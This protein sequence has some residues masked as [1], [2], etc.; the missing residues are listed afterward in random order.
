MRYLVTNQNRLFES[1]EYK[2]IDIKTALEL[3]NKENILGVD[4]ETSGLDA[5]SK[6][7]LLLQIG[8]SEFQVAVDC[9][10]VNIL[11]FKSLLE[12]KNKLFLF[13]NAKFDLQFLYKYGIIVYNIYDSFL[14]ER[15]LWIGYPAGIHLLSLQSLCESYLDIYLDK[16]VR[17]E[18]FKGLTERVVVYG[19]RDV[20]FLLPLREKQ[21]EQIK[22]KELERAVELENEFVRALAYIEWCGIKLDV[23][24]WKAKMVT[25]KIKLEETTNALNKW[26]SD[27]FPNSE[28]CEINYQGDLF[29]GFD[30]TPK[31]KLNWQSSKQLIPF[32]EMLGYKLETKDKKTGEIKKSIEVKILE[33]QGGISSILPIYLEYS[34]AAKIVSTYGQNIINQINSTTGR[35]HT[36]Y[37]SLGADTG[38]LSSGGK[39]KETGKENMN[40]QN[41]PADAITRGCFVAEPGNK[42]ICAD[43]SAQESN[44]IACIADDKAMI[45]AINSG[46]DL[47]NLTAYMS[48]MEIPRDTK[49]ADIKSKFKKLRDKSKKVEFAINY[50]GNA[51]TIKENVGISIEDANNVYNNYMKGFKGV[52]KY[53]DFRRKEVIEKGYILINKIIGRKAFIYDYNTFLIP[54]KEIQSSPGY[55]EDYRRKKAAGVEDDLILNARKYARRKSTSEQQS[56]NYP[57]QGTAADMTKIAIIKLF[58]WIID[59][60]N[61]DIV[62]IVATTHDEIEVESPEE[63]SKLVASKVQECMETAGDIFCKQVKI[64]AIPEIADCWVH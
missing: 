28:F 57:I 32:F 36:N 35:I 13:H 29:E 34:S 18:I 26:V 7:I 25:D 44:I 39:D 12:N 21:L 33:R 20:E 54:Q 9:T 17:G 60:N 46:T 53:Q 42:M 5:H 30:L 3:L 23:D 61:F 55:W 4:T 64:K 62:L 2:I 8:T 52:K 16:S 45:D 19:C 14:V 24:K 51:N 6:D 43:Y 22:I 47:H 31:C 41:L 11:E 56:V 38:R 63:K 50:A 48:F 10:T 27:N 40:L 15:L 49:I 1:N 37:N 59:S 58:N